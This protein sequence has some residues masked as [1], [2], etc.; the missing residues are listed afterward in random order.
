MFFT[1]HLKDQ[2]NLM[3]CF[4]KWQDVE[5][6]EKMVSLLAYLPWDC[7][8][9]KHGHLGIPDVIY[10]SECIQRNFPVKVKTWKQTSKPFQ[11]HRIFS[12]G[13]GESRKGVTV[14]TF[15]K[16]SIVDTQIKS[17]KLKPMKNIKPEGDGWSRELVLLRQ[18]VNSKHKQQ[19]NLKT[20]IIMEL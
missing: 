11:K 2:S 7:V 18:K 9:V 6:L 3:Y 20:L 13:T 4:I 8:G 15:Y 19:L 10:H 5:P 14:L 1:I 17:V 16:G 12:L